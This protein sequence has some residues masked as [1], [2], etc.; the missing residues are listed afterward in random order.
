[1]GHRFDGNA[2]TGFGD[3]GVMRSW[4]PTTVWKCL[5]AGGTAALLAAPATAAPWVRGYVID[6]YEPAF[7]YGAK[8][9][10]MEGGTDCPKGTTPDND[11]Q[12]L[13]KTRWRSD[14]EIAD[15]LR[16]ATLKVNG[17]FN[18]NREF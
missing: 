15:V 12:A 17:T 18:S 8:S 11:Y 9:G 3:H 4:Q 6:K 1:M 7:Y 5:L 13:L 2:K 16:S 10:T 14:A